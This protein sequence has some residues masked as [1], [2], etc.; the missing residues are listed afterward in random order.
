[1]RR[2]WFANRLILLAILILL[3]IG[4]IAVSALGFL[5]PIEDLLGSPLNWVT[6][7]FTDVGDSVINSESEDLSVAEL[8][9]RNAELERQLAQLQGELI[10]LREIAA[11]YDRLTELLDY[12]SSADNLEFITADVVGE[13]QYGFINSI[14]I[15]K[16]TRDGLTIGLP[17][18]TE[19]GLVGR[20]WRVT[21]NTAQVQ[22]ITDRNSNVSAR[23][24]NSRADGTIQGEGLAD[25]SL[26]LLLVD[27]DVPIEPGELIYSSGL[28]GTFPADIALGQVIS[29]SNV[30]S[31]LTQQAQVSSL[32][33]FSTLQQVLVVTNFE[34][35]DLSVFD[36]PEQ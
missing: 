26:E 25:G 16:G 31:E 35:V 3:C 21:A 29:V 34:A 9:A 7:I 4:M 1:M 23:L 24:Q 15:N 11:D 10:T 30:E 18:V 33:N 36:E 6:Q 28:G 20:I 5:R 19:L 8:Q 32:I 12:V 22:L 17:V 13:G 14:L 2:N 27:L